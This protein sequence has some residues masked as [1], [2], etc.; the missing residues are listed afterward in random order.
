MRSRSPS[1][2]PGDVGESVAA[3]PFRLLPHQVQRASLIH[4][5]NHFLSAVQTHLLDAEADHPNVDLRGAMDAL[6][7][8][9]E[10]VRCLAKHDVEATSNERPNVTDGEKCLRDIAHILS[11]PGEVA[12]HVRAPRQRVAL[13][14]TELELKQ[15][16]MNLVVNALEANAQIVVLSL[17]LSRSGRASVRVTDDGVGIPP[18]LL[19][20]IFEPFL[21]TKEKNQGLGLSSV[22]A[23]VERCAG[24]VDVES[25]EGVGTSFI[26]RVPGRPAL[27]GSPLSVRPSAEPPAANSDP[28]QSGEQPL[29][30]KR[31]A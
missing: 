6:M 1:E 8:A 15:V 14:M 27:A 13:D 22:R 29:R 26:V 7:S 30:T 3:S 4:D 18:E 12:I 31:R 23:I 25:K 21:S 5:L 2:R 28:G 11:R 20:R 24:Q 16:L 9:A 19:A 17:D 10:I